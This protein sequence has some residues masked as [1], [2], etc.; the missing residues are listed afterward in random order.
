MTWNM[1]ELGD[2]FTISSSKRVHKADWQTS[3]IPFYRAREIVTLS[4]E[5]VV[6]NELFISE[7][8]YEDHRQ[9]YGV[10]K[11]GDIMVSGVGTVGAC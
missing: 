3:G 11:S 5:G 1:V 9:K 7:E 8:L 6:D 4:K 10:P 2:L